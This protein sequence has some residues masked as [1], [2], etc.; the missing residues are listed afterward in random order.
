M[1]Y[2]NS[3]FCSKLDNF[4]PEQHFGLASETKIDLQMA[5]QRG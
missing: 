2:V 1:E 4:Y 3:F 5:G